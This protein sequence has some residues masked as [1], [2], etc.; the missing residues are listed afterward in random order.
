MTVLDAAA[1]NHRRSHLTLVLIVTGS[2]L[3]KA[4]VIAWLDGRVYGDVLRSVNFG[5]GVGEGLISITTHVDNTRSFLGPMLNAALYRAGGVWAIKLFNALTFIGLCLAMIRIG[6]RRFAE[7]VV[8]VALFLL[9]FYAGGHRNVVAGEVEDNLA[10]L[11]FAAGLLLH[12]ETRRTLPASVLMGVALLLKFWIAIFLGAFGLFLMMRR[13]WRD[14]AAMT[15]GGLLPFALVSSIDGGATV[16][17]L[18]MTVD[19]QQGYSTWTLVVARLL[20]TGLL[21]TIAISAWTVRKRPSNHGTLFFTLVASYFAYVLLFRDAHAITFVMMLCLVPAGF[22]VADFLVHSPLVGAGRPGRLRLTVV[23]ALY[24]VGNLGIAWQ[25]LYRDT[26]P[27][28]VAP[29]RDAKPLVLGP[30]GR[31]GPGPL[32]SAGIVLGPE[33][34]QAGVRLGGI[35]AATTGNGSELREDRVAVRVVQ[36][37]PDVRFEGASQPARHVQH[38]LETDRSWPGIWM[39]HALH[40]S[41]RKR[42]PVVRKMTV[43]RPGAGDGNPGHHVAEHVE[44]VVGR[45]AGL[46]HRGLWRH[47]LLYQHEG[48]RERGLEQRREPLA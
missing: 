46:V 16:R 24:A 2:V 20:S 33:P 37:H 48:P 15:V 7:R 39:Q 41:N 14:A 43:V 21:P 22:L 18:L 38:P 32:Q 8:V 5:L 1:S 30:S 25:N 45:E 35:A 9:A 19:R 29:G 47:V 11:M 6:R 10:S 28:Q 36:V 44:P 40:D 31:R 17:S 13:R 34:L 26:H 3:L 27:F 12:L 23:L 42:F 4:G